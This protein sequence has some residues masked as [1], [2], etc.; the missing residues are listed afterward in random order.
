M[1][2]LDK[3]STCSI[4]REICMSMDAS[5]MSPCTE[6]IRPQNR[7]VRMFKEFIGLQ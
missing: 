5:Y 4:E 6:Y 7:I 1:A 3:Y 2:V